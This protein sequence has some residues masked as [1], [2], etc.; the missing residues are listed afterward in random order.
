MTIGDLIANTANMLADVL[1]TW[2]NYVFK[3]QRQCTISSIKNEGK[4]F[5]KMA[6]IG[7]GL[8]K[9]TSTIL[10]SIFYK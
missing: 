5:L 6:N 4:L 10:E 8:P 2:S 1:K 9:R 7:E 3:G